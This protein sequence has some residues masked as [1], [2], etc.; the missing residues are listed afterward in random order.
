[1]PAVRVVVAEG[2][3]G[4][5]HLV[6]G[7]H[8]AHVVGL[9]EARMGP[10]HAR[11]RVLL[12]DAL[13]RVGIGMRVQKDLALL[14]QFH[15]PP[16]HGQVGV[17]AEHVK[18]ADAGVGVGFQPGFHVRNDGRIPHPGADF[19]AP[20]IGAQHR[21]DE[22]GRGLVEHLRAVV[23]RAGDEGLFHAG[24]AQHLDGFGR[25][26]HGP[27]VVAVVDMRVHDR[28]RFIGSSRAGAEQTKRHGKY[29]VCA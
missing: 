3:I 14:G 13:H 22:I 26:H 8:G 23:A 29:D 11:V 5:Q 24:L 9:V 7:K 16:H 27:G 15:Q 6:L 28:A 17:R 10:Q 1:M 12:E 18:L 21:H 19:T 20:A 25:R 4:P 2:Q